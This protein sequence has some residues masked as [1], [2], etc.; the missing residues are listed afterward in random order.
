[1]EIVH[2]GNRMSAELD[3]HV[4]FT[5]SGTGGRAVC[6]DRHDS[7]RRLRSCFL[8]HG[9]GDAVVEAAQL[10]GGRRPEAW[11][12]VDVDEAYIH[13]SKHVP[14]MKRLDKQI[15]WGTDDESVKGGD[16][17]KVRAEA[18]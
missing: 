17:F 15:A 10:T 11:I 2:S 6:L 8:R 9:R 12:V 16:Y 14:L 7:H 13:C 18:R 3:D 4:A 5:H 1:M